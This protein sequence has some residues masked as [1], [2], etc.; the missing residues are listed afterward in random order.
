M[1]T[2]ACHRCASR[3]DE[4]GLLGGLLDVRHDGDNDEAARDA[5]SDEDEEECGEDEVVPRLPYAHLRVVLQQ[6]RESFSRPHGEGEAN[7][8][9]RLHGE[10]VH[11]G[12]QDAELEHVNLHQ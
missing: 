5:D 3:N 8:E 2:C 10:V 1:K 7:D 6:R 11:L 9:R 4:R 12:L